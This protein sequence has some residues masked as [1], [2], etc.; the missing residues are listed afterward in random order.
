MNTRLAII[1]AECMISNFVCMQYEVTKRYT[2]TMNNTYKCVSRHFCAKTE[3]HEK[4]RN[5]KKWNK[6]PISKWIIIIY[7]AKMFAQ[8]EHWEKQKLKTLTY[9]IESNYCS[10]SNRNWIAGNE[11]RTY[12]NSV[13]STFSSMPIF[14]SQPLI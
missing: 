6:K 10:V 7:V 9:R 3:W 8:R 14:D 2:E 11:I 1:F 4:K 5:E 12:K 13:E